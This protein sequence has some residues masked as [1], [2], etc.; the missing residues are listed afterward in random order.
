MQGGLLH[1]HRIGNLL[2]ATVVFLMIRRPP[3]STLFPYTTL[4]RS[5][6]RGRG[7]GGGDARWSGPR[8]TRS[9]ADG[10]AAGGGAER[11]SRGPRREAHL[12]RPRLAVLVGDLEELLLFEVERPRDEHGGEGLDPPVEVLHVVVVEAP[13]GLDPV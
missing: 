4:F 3:R 11:H 1:V 10:P 12:G 13:A 7:P 9:A 8:A 6:R 5:P 2:V